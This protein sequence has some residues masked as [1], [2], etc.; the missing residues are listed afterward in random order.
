MSV[1]L[2]TATTMSREMDMHF[3][4]EQADAELRELA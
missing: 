4:L 3:G 1:H 2:A